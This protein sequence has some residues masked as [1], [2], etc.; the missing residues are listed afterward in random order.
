MKKK[1]NLSK[2][3]GKKILGSVGMA[4]LL[5]SGAALAM[6]SAD[7][8]EMPNV[9]MFKT[10]R[11]NPMPMLQ[12][13]NIEPERNFDYFEELNN[14]YSEKFVIKSGILDEEINSMNEGAVYDALKNGN[15][16]EWKKAVKNLAGYP[17]GVDTISEEE[18]NILVQLRNN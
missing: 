5:F 11:D 2:N 1:K 17:A 7:A 4:V 14:T 13:N 12:L 3:R 6:P 10:V 18:F 8:R 9:G 16:K 15:Y